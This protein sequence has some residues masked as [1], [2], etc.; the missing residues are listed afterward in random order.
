MLAIHVLGLLGPMRYS[1]NDFA[2]AFEGYSG[3][4]TGVKVCHKQ[5]GPVL[6]CGAQG[7]DLNVR[8][9]ATVCHKH[10][11]VRRYERGL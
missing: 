10:R 5:I 9:A 7:S 8:P 2:C 1:C 6:A 11:L 3:S 4:E